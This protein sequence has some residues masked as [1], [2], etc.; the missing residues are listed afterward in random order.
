MDTRR[1][2]LLRVW[3]SWILV[4]LM[5]ACRPQVQDGFASSQSLITALREAGARVEDTAIA[6]PP[7]FN[8]RAART[9]QVDRGLVYVYE[10]AEVEEA[11]AVT[12]RLAPDGLSLSGTP[13]PWE[14]RVSAWQAGQ[15]VV[16]YPGTEGGLVLLLSGLLGDPLTAQP[17][18]PEEPYPPA[19]AA[20]LVA[21]ADSQALDPAGVEVIGYTAAEWLDGCLGLPASGESCA[22]GAV[23]GW[24][25]DLRAGER[26]GSAHTD[27][28]G[29]QVRLASG[30]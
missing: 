22:P 13:L 25:V 18:G 28:L 11:E 2:S 12:T 23:R 17:E 8:A 24:V 10:Y 26:T 27:D 1:R 20:A 30:D 6:A 19:V 21:W 14:G 7:E 15:I 5:A 29:L 3:S 4:I 9:L 16:V